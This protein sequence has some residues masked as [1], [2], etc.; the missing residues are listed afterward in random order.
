MLDGTNIFPATNETQPDPVTAASAAA[1][2]D[3]T[4]R[5]MQEEYLNRDLEIRLSNAWRRNGDQNARKRLILSHQRL[6]SRL[7]HQLKRG[8][9]KTND[10]MQEAN[11]GLMKAADKFD[12]ETGNRFSTYAAWWI[13]A[14]I[15]DAMMR[16]HSAVRLKNSSV[17]RTA[18]HTL[19]RI[20]AK[21]VATLRRKKEGAE[22]T[23]AEV[24]AE[25][26][27]IMGISVVALEKIKA[28]MP[29]A[30]SLNEQRTG[31]DGENQSER[32]EMLASDEPDAEEIVIRKTS[33]AELTNAIANAMG[34][35]NDREKQIVMARKMTDV[36]KTLEELSH[37]YNVTRERV[38]QI[39]CR[40][41][42]KMRRHLEAAGIE[43]SDF[44]SAS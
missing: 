8:S 24:H 26:A 1:E 43:G 41:L 15:Q 22:P 31:E 11:I 27:R 13:R 6:A 4:S 20:E 36:P 44:L 5:A 42:Q 19:P 18:Y 7:V 23:R 33:R 34:T 17:N 3:L 14:A 37:V 10:L 25:T 32:I 30:I 35:L 12:P 21:A 28:V 40:G 16:D 29:A 39:E 38:R 9:D 2:L